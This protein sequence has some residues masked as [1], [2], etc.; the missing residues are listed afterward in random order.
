MMVMVQVLRILKSWRRLRLNIFEESEIRVELYNFLKSEVR[1]LACKFGCIRIYVGDI[2]SVC[3]NSMD[4]ALSYEFHG[5][6]F[7]PLDLYILHMKIS[8]RSLC[9]TYETVNH[10]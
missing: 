2:F 6:E 8:A 9:S 1:V 7:G 4:N 3:L 10:V 5:M